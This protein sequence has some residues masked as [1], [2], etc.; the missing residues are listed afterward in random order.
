MTIQE[1]EKKKGIEAICD[2]TPH[3]WGE[4]IVN[5]YNPIDEREDRTSF[6]IAAP[7]TDQGLK[8][9]NSLYKDF[10]K[11]NRLPRDTVESLVLTC[12]AETYVELTQ[13]C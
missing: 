13:I 5:F 8:E 7:L 12:V 10:C 9:L 4:I 11:E 2:I 3:R 1:C 6:D